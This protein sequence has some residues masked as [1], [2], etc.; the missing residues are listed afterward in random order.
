MVDI[1]WSIVCLYDGDPLNDP[2]E[3]IASQRRSFIRAH[4]DATITVGGANL[5]YQ[6]TPEMEFEMIDSLKG[7]TSDE[8][9]RVLM[10]LH[11]FPVNVMVGNP[12]PLARVTVWQCRMGTPGVSGT[13]GGANYSR[14]MLARGFVGRTT[15]RYNGRPDIVAM[16]CY[17]NKSQMQSV[18][19]GITTSQRCAWRFGDSRCGY[20]ITDATVTNVNVTNISNQE[21]FLTIDGSSTIA[22]G[23]ANMNAGFAAFQQGYAEFEGLKILIREHLKQSGSNYVAGNGAVVN[24]NIK[25]LLTFKP[26]THPNYTWVGKRITLV[27]G[28][29]KNKSACQGKWG[30]QEHFGGFGLL[31]PTYNPVWEV[32][33]GLPG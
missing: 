33:G 16:E 22:N 24:G 13:W 5:L 31:I 15:A 30:N 26:P 6:A 4:D 28:C 9:F 1:E 17:R 23:L 11:L 14:R 8:P 29:T 20:P 27:G 3:E 12:F 19:L 10:P 21:M 25:L 2:C 7:G 32:G 18:S